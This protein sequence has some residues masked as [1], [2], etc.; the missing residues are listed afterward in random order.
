MLT[1]RIKFNGIYDKRTV[2]FLNEN[3]I[4]DF[5]LDFRPR[6]LNFIQIHLAQKITMLNTL[7]NF[8]LEFDNERDFI[9]KKVVEDLLVHTPKERLFL[10]FSDHQDSHFYEQF[11][12]PYYLNID[13][14]SKITPSFLCGSNLKGVIFDGRFLASQHQNGTFASFVNSFYT[15]IKNNSIDLEIC[16]FRDW[17]LDLFPSIDAYFDFDKICLPINSNIEKCFRNVDLNKIGSELKHLS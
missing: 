11:N 9:I 5:S 1:P 17:T 8:Y 6:S 7:S 13:S 12:C 15:I 2:K 4:F 16:L 10:E 3:H 14:L